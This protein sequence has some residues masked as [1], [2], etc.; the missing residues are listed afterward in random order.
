M[1]ILRFVDTCLSARNEN[2]Y[3]E[4][5]AERVQ[6]FLVQSHHSPNSTLIPKLRPSRDRI[7]STVESLP[8]FPDRLDSPRAFGSER[9]KDTRK[10]HGVSSTILPPAV[11]AA[12]PSGFSNTPTQP[13]TTK[14]SSTA[15]GLLSPST[16]ITT[17]ASHGS[18][19]FR[20]SL[21]AK[22]PGT[23]PATRRGS[24]RQPRAHPPPHEGDRLH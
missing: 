18:Q 14:H 16:T 23:R 20:R 8:N 10:A 24:A 13:A 21:L 7:R 2:E 11:F 19:P 4:S 9:E 22:Q 12:S 1:Y 17:V 5:G 3:G 15:T 6:G